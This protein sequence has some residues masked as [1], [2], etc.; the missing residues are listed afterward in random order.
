MSLAV[1]IVVEGGGFCGCKYRDL[2]FCSKI[3]FGLVFCGGDFV[4]HEI[5][6]NLHFHF[7]KHQ[8]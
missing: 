4:F 3:Y 2:F 5:S 6:V 8:S 7:S 1:I